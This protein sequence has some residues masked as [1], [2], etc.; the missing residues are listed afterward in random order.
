[1]HET[2]ECLKGVLKDVC[3]KFKGCVNDISTS[4][5]G[6]AAD[7]IKDMCESIYYCTVTDAMEQVGPEERMGYRS[8][9]PYMDGDI[10]IPRYGYNTGNIRY[11][12]NTRMGYKPMVG[13]EPY[14]YNYI[15]DYG[16][17]YDKYK[18]A[19]KHYTETHSTEDKHKMNDTTRKHLNN[20]LDSLSEMWEDAEP[21]LKREI[22]SE[23]TS[24]VG[25]M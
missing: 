16:P 9:M 4:E 21:D 23:L 13:Q 25:K 6:E 1:M 19:K 8:R 3:Y 18:M 5:A 24:T 10:D 17:E 15:S 12:G 2:A 11:S 14:V 20:M 7:I 22:K